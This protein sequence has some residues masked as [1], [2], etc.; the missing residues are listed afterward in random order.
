MKLGDKMLFGIVLMLNHKKYRWAEMR[1][2]DL[3]VQ[4]NMFYNSNSKCKIKHLTGETHC[5]VAI[6]LSPC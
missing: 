2:F 4:S 3:F 6:E 5:V 1:I